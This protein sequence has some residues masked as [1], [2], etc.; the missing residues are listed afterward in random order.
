MRLMNTRRPEMPSVNSDAPTPRRL[1]AEELVS[2]L[3]KMLQ[4]HWLEPYLLPIQNHI[5]ALEAELETARKEGREYERGV[6]SKII[7]TATDVRSGKTALDFWQQEMGGGEFSADDACSMVGLLLSDHAELET[8][9]GH[10]HDL[11]HW[12]AIPKADD[13]LPAVT[14]ARRW[15]EEWERR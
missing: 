8:A 3:G 2:A 14:A 11:L 13:R 9:A 5:A 7:L 1:T 12:L 4:L 15:L 6:W 10:V